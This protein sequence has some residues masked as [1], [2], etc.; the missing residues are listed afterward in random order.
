MAIMIHPVLNIHVELLR[1]PSKQQT[2]VI[3]LRNLYFGKW[4]KIAML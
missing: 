2:L 4:E 3:V 1:L